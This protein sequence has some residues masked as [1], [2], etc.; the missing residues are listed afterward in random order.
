MP[1]AFAAPPACHAPL[2]IDI[3]GTA[4]T[5]IDRQ[6]LA[7]PLVGGMI[8]FGRNTGAAWRW[9]IDIF[10]IACVLFSAT[11]VGILYLHAKNRPMAWPG[12]V[13]TN[14]RDS[15]GVVRSKVAK[16]NSS[17]KAPKKLACTMLAQPKSASP[18]STSGSSG[19]TNSTG[20]KHQA[21]N[22]RWPRAEADRPGSKAGVKN[23]SQ[24]AMTR[25]V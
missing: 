3:A 24:A 20:A 10:A 1:T 8:L 5:D 2:I 15:V 9:F 4:L 16:K 17:T 13:G 7:H 25:Q 19:R 11:G 23:N 6:R 12:T 18:P 22:S 21:A 14:S